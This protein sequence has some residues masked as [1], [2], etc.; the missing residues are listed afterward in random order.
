MRSTASAMPFSVARIS[1]AVL[2][3]GLVGV[4][5]TA[6]CD[7]GA[8]RKLPGRDHAKDRPPARPAIRRR[9]AGRSALI[10]APVVVAD[11]RPG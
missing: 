9:R 8:D 10:V 11:L 2:G 1:A 6:S 7:G 5:L 3:S 4:G